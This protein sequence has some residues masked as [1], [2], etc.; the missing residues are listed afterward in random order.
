MIDLHCHLLPSVDDGPAN[1]NETL[2]LA[3]AL[4]NDGVTVVAATPHSYAFRSD[5]VYDPIRIRALVSETKSK[6]AEEGLALAVVHGTEIR[7]NEYIYSRLLNEKL[8]CYENTRT[9]LLE[10]SAYVSPEELEVAMGKLNDMNYQIVLAHPEK[11]LFVEEESNILGR[12]LTQGVVTQIN[13]SNVSGMGGPLRQ[14]ICEE[15][16]S[17]RFVH[18]VSSD[19]HNSTGPRMPMMSRAYDLLRKSVGTYVDLLF[20]TN[21]AYILNGNFDCIS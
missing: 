19:A 5:Q 8:L 15:L 4:I 17:K 10:T 20:K 12:F 9:L 21:P 11:I 7:L 14:C 1:W 6:L 16:I 13:A 18:I 2:D 3:R